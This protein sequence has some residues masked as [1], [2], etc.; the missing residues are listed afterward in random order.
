MPLTKFSIRAQPNVEFRKA[1]AK[2]ASDDAYRLTALQDPSIITKDFKL[3]PHDLSALRNVAILSG[4]RT[5]AISLAH[6]SLEA[7]DI[8]INISCCCCCCCGDTGAIT[9]AA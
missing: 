6:G 4:A 1:L 9:S 2:L 3:T 7:A 8:N 5:S